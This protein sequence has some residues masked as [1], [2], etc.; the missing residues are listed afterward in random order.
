MMFTPEIDRQIYLLH[1]TRSVFP[2]LG[3]ELVGPKE[4]ESPDYYKQLGFN[5][6]VEV[7][8]GI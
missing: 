1:R 3:Q 4:F 7:P 5:A 6:T 8:K 2:R